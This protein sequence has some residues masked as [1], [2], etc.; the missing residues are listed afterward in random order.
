MDVHE[1]NRV[2]AKLA[3][4]V[5]DVFATVPR[6]DQRAKSDCYLRGLMLDG[7]RK[8]IQAMTSRLRDGNEQNLQQFV[9]QS[10]WD[11]LP[12]RRRIAER[13]TARISPEAWVIDDVS[14]PKDGRMSV[15]VAPQYCGALG[16]RANCQVAV[17]VHAC[18][19]TASCPLQW[20]LFLP[21]EWV[22]DAERRAACRVP[23]D[24]GHREKWRLAL[25]ILDELAG[26]GT[27]SRVILADAAYGTNAAFRGELTQRGLSY[28]LS[29]RSGVTAHPFDAVPEAPARKGVQGCW[30]QPRYR[31]PPPAV[32]ALA[33][34]LGSEAFTNVTWRQGSRGPMASRFAALRVRPAGNAIIRPLRTRASAEQGWWDGILPDLWLL[35]EWPQNAKAPTEY[36]F[37][38]LPTRTPLQD[39]VHYAKLRWRVEHDYRELKHGLGLDHFEGRSWPGWQHHVTLVTAAHAFL[40][41]QR[42]SPK[43]STPA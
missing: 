13:M 21:T 42:L 12:V 3:F 10:T 16:K 6:T 5:D 43:A 25:D 23:A 17:S 33:T 9:N 26:W 37:S 34:A 19:A 29:V 40:T 18:T 2:R 36:W 4:F 27:A 32:A 20:R 28:V 39:L 31:Q 35:A 24:I 30:P 38:N 14:F 8:S 7:R 22:D 15:A 1:V 11:P 41:E